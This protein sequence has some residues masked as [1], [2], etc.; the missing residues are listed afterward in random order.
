MGKQF[1]DPFFTYLLKNCKGTTPQIYIVYGKE[2]FFIKAIII[3]QFPYAYKHDSVN[4]NILY[5][6]VDLP[7]YTLTT[8]SINEIVFKNFNHYVHY[9]RLLLLFILQEKSHPYT[10]H[11]LISIRF[12]SKINFVLF[13]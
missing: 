5:S 4:C 9:N 7:L 11:F 13:I 3:I 6:V 8:L 12:V 2:L 10:Q 1:D